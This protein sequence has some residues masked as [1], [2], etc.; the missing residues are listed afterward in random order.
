MKLSFKWLLLAL[1]T[2]LPLAV[3]MIAGFVALWEND[4]LFAWL[5]MSS[6]IAL[7][8]WLLAGRL[9]KTTLIP[10]PLRVEPP[11]TWTRQGS[12]SWE[13]V[14]KLAEEI[15]VRESEIKD[16][17]TLWTIFQE[18]I[19]TVA[20]DF[21]PRQKSPI[22]EVRIPEL[23][24]VIELLSGDLREAL[25]DNI[26]GSHILTINDL[27]RGQRYFAR[28]KDLYRLY[29]ILSIGIDPVS[30]ALRELR[31][32]AAGKL[33]DASRLEL[34]QWLLDAYVK[35]IGY[36]AIALYSGHLVLDDER[37]ADFVTTSSRRDLRKMQAQEARAREEPLRILVLG[38][39]KAGKSSVINALFG[40]T[41]ALVDVLPLTSGVQ[42]YLLEKEGL[43]KAI[44]YDTAGYED[45]A[46]PRRPLREARREILRSDLILMV[47]S[48]S[49]AARAADRNILE[50]V[51]N[52]FA[53]DRQ[54]DPPP[55]VVVLTHID[56]LRPFRE[57]NPPYD[58]E[59]KNN[60]KARLIRD[61]LMAVAEDLKVTPSQVVPVCA[62]V[63]KEYNITEGLTPVILQSLGGTQRLKYLRCLK[64]YQN[65]EYWQK[66]WVQ[67]KNT[68]R[69][70]AEMGTRWL[71]KL[72]PSNK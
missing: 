17:Q 64:E 29:R 63:G 54:E 15:S 59:N 43:E 62:K 40:E 48:A 72:D 19:E 7:L 69:F 31:G 5:G 1:I 24:K 10:E 22:L 25:T 37:F 42:P 58:I 30:A 51:Q 26:P 8:S 36:Y 53:E 60:P 68:G 38:Q 16:W 33:L 34:Q 23:L 21:H 46:N 13:K 2:V 20:Q 11:S 61:A 50:M 12:K 55:V 57:W 67:S 41:K 52:A 70:L 28:G 71:A 66:L 49:T 47:C 65:E 18:V 9:R 4:W 27:I 45:P 35:K 6:V 14:E 56:R 44:I 32:L 3:L 39:L